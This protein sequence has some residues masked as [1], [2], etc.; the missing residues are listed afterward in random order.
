[1]QRESTKKPGTNK[2]V[3]APEATVLCDSMRDTTAPGDSSQGSQSL[4]AS[5]TVVAPPLVWMRY[6]DSRLKQFCSR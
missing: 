5:Q 3:A 4:S 2:T 6:I 1:M